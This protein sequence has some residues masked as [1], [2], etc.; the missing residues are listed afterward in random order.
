MIK[1]NVLINRNLSII[2]KL[3]LQLISIIFIGVAPLYLEP[4]FKNEKELC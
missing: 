2:N 1:H 3:Y 4:D